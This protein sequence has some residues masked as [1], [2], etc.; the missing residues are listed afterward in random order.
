MSRLAIFIQETVKSTDG[1]YIPCI[2]VEGEK[3]FYK[4]DWKWGW[5]KVK[6][7]EWANE[8]NARVGL[9]P[10]DVLKIVLGT[11]KGS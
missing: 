10:E 1:Q 8:R 4:T 2:A 3:G 7:E 5:D 9:S 11:M 6:A